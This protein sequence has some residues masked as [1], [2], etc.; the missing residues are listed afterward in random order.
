MSGAD[1]LHQLNV[2]ISL[3]QS[4]ADA[5]IGQPVPARNGWKEINE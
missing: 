3:F 2:Y 4:T 5:N 1:I